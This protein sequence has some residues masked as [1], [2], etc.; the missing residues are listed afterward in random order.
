MP[1]S[2]AQARCLL[3]ALVA[4]ALDS[5]RAAGAGQ[6]HTN[7]MSSP[8]PEAVAAVFTA[9]GGTDSSRPGA[10][11]E[12]NE[13]FTLNSAYLFFFMHCGFAMVSAVVSWTHPFTSTSWTCIVLRSVILCMAID[14]C[15]PCGLC[16]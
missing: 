11:Y 1:A 13:G 4:A 5:T 15:C 3:V 7:A 12:V 10:F 16:C 14:L 2:E 8:E 9:F 6:Q